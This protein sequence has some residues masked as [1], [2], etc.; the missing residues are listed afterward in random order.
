M[1]LRSNFITTSSNFGFI[2]PQDGSFEPL[3]KIIQKQTD[4]LSDDV[5]NKKFQQL[6]LLTNDEWHKRFNLKWGGYPSLAQWLEILVEKPLTDEEIA[7][8]KIEYE[9][10][11][12]FKASIVGVWCNDPNLLTSFPQRYKNRDN[13][14]IKAIIDKYCKVKE[15]L[16]DDRIKKMAE[17]LKKQLNSDKS[18]FY[19]SL[20]E[21]ARNQQPLLT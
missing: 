15:D 6:W 5:V 18:K 11:L 1:E 20:R 4:K 9:D 3:F 16:A 7:K 17:Y 13:I 19:S 2:L 14:E 10:N 8:R 12:R 21:I